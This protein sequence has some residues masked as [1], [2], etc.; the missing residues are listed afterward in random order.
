LA[1]SDVPTEVRS[2]VMRLMSEVDAL[3][4]EL[5]Q[6]RERVHELETMAD[7]DPLLPMLNRR[8]FVRELERVLAYMKR[9]GT[10]DSLIY[11]DL[12]DFKSINDTHGHA[13]GDAALQRVAEL[14]IQHLRRSDIVG[15]LGGDE[16]AIVLRQADAAAAQRKAA[17][18]AEALR[19]DR[20]VHG[21]VELPLAMT[22][23][24]T[25][26]E[27]EDT[28]ESAL[29]RADSQMYVRKQTRKR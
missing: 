9:H 26:L 22:A 20:F 1:L 6:A 23:G 28:V 5:S 25:Q 27:R 29:E 21:G 13:A 16:F 17:Q 19:A 2:E 8:G 12:N 15:R 7:E 24:V 14:L 11:C 3:K 18:L 4:A 10:V